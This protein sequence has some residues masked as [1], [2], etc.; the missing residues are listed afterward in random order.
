MIRTDLNDVIRYRMLTTGVLRL[1]GIW[2]IASRILPLVSQALVIMWQ[3]SITPNFSG[4]LSNQPWLWGNI[5]QAVIYT[6]LGLFLIVYARRLARKII[7]TATSRCPGCDYD[8]GA[9]PPARCPECGLDL[10]PLLPTPVQSSGADS[11]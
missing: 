2:I 7:P 4:G 3:D 10:S 11:Q 6:L 1:M 9:A 8:L 5:G